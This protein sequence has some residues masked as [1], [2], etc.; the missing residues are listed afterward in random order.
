MVVRMQAVCGYHNFDCNVFYVYRY[1]VF[2][3]P[4]K[5][6]ILV[7]IVVALGYVQIWLQGMPL[8]G[9]GISVP[10]ACCEMQY[11]FSHYS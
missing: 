10:E 5:G 7:A 11:L 4:K 8:N 6:R 2:M 9:P 1:I 3:S